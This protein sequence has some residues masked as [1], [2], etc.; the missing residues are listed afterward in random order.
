MDSFTSERIGCLHGWKQASF[1][2]KNPK[3]SGKG[4][5][6]EATLSGKQVGLGIDHGEMT[7]DVRD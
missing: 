1:W 6:G 4:E 7:W 5:Q 3:I 2:K